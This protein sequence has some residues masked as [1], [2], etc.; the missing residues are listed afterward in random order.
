MRVKEG[1]EGAVERRNK[2][3]KTV[4]E[5]Y[6]PSVSGTISNIEIKTTEYEGRKF[7]T[8]KITLDDEIQVQM[9]GSM[10]NA[11]NK[12]IINTLMSPDCDL[13]KP[14][15]FIATLDD[16][17]Y[18]EIFIMQGKKGIRRFSTKD[19][20]NGVPQPTKKKLLGKDVWD[21]SKQDEWYFDEFHKLAEKINEFMPPEPEEI[22]EEP[23]Q[24]VEAT[25][26]DFP[27]AKKEKLD[28][29]VNPD[30]IPF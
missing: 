26:D 14:L 10:N 9:P 8:M 25:V 17:G 2:N 18:T 6:Y 11:Q 22:K 4:F 24:D 21:W 12:K 27:D 13:R 20:P 15:D 16:A 29:G 5:K 30:D 19:N 28:E 23:V 7:D 3:E 1:V